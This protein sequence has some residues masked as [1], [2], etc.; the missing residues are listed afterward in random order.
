MSQPL[1]YMEGVLKTAETVKLQHTLSPASTSVCSCEDDH[2]V[3][4]VACACISGDNDAALRFKSLLGPA[5]AVGF[6]CST[7]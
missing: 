7:C 3:R 1:H 5:C 4:A 2:G 6:C